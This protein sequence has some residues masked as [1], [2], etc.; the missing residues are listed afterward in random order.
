MFYLAQILNPTPRLDTV[1]FFIYGTERSPRPTAGHT[2]VDPL[3]IKNPSQASLRLNK[4]SVS[5]K[6]PLNKAPVPI[7]KTGNTP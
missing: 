3:S 1:N 5:I 7:K 2:S 4:E 6:G